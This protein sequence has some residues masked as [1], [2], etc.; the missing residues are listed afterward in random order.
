[1]D[2]SGYK[3]ILKKINTEYIDENYDGLVAGVYE[4]R[5]RAIKRLKYKKAAYTSIEAGYLLMEAF[6]DV[7]GVNDYDI[8]IEKGD[9]GKPYIKDYPEFKYNISHSGEYV[10]IAYGCDDVGID[11]EYIREKDLKIAKRC[12]HKDEYAYITK[13]EA[14]QDERFF[15]VWTMK[16]AYLKYTGQGINVSLDSFVVEPDNQ[17]IRGIDVD[18]LVKNINGILVAICGKNLSDVEYKILI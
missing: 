17:K 12:F 13:N 5:R 4:Q 18:I 3:I 11:I 14:G 7:Y 15:E 10:A 8:C 1:M 2:M 16:E 6:K 9:F